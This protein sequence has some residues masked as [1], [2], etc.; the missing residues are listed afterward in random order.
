MSH[1][2]PAKPS[3]ATT[4]AQAVPGPSRPAPTPV[5]TLVPSA[6]NPTS[7]LLISAIGLPP[8]AAV[9]CRSWTGSDDAIE[10]ARK[11]VFGIAAGAPDISAALAA[12]V[13]PDLRLTLWAFAVVAE[14]G[15]PRLAALDFEDEGL[16]ETTP[17]VCRFELSH[18]HPCSAHCAAGNPCAECTKYKPPSICPFSSRSK[19][20]SRPVRQ[21][22]G[23]M[24]RLWI[25]ALRALVL[26]RL[27][28]PHLLPT[29]HGVLLNPPHASTGEWGRQW[30][31]QRSLTHAHV[32]ISLSHPLPRPSSPSHILIHLYPHQT[33][34]YSLPPSN[35]PLVPGTPLR[36]LPA[37][38]PAYA[39]A[40]Y[41]GPT[42]SGPFGFPQLLG[43]RGVP[44]SA[45]VSPCILVWL[46]L[47]PATTTNV[48]SPSGLPTPS[49]ATPAA[50]AGPTGSRGMYAIWPRN[51]C[52]VDSKL[53]TIDVA[54]LPCLPAGL[55]TQGPGWT[56]PRRFGAK[57]SKPPK[58]I[59]LQSAVSC[60]PSTSTTQDGD[61]SL[62]S[63]ANTAS[64]LI[65]AVVR[66]REKEKEKQRAR[67]ER[68][69]SGSIPALG[70]TSG[71]ATGPSTPVDAVHPINTPTAPQ[72][73]PQLNPH[74]HPHPHPQPQPPTQTQ[75]PT[76]LEN[77]PMQYVG[78][79]L[80]LNP[81][82]LQQPTVTSPTSD[83][84][85]DLFGDAE[86][87]V[88]SDQDGVFPDLSFTDMDTWNVSE[89]Q[90]DSKSNDEVQDSD[91][92]FFGVADPW[93][94]NAP[95]AQAPAPTQ[96]QAQ[97]QA[98][99][100]TQMDV[101]TIDLELDV[102]PSPAKD[103]TPIP[104]PPFFPLTPPQ[105]EGG[106]EPLKFGQKYENVDG[107]YSCQDGK[108]GVR[109]RLVVPEPRPRA[110]TLIQAQGTVEEGRNRLVRTQSFS[111]TPT[112]ALARR[113]EVGLGLRPRSAS[114][115]QQVSQLQA[116]PL[117]IQPKP[118]PYVFQAR[119]YPQL[120]LHHLPQ[121][122]IKNQLP[123]PS[124]S[125]N[126]RKLRSGYINLTNP[127]AKRIRTLKLAHSQ[128]VA[129][130]GTGVFTRDW[131]PIAAP[132]SPTATMSSTSDDEGDDE[133][134]DEYIPGTAPRS[135]A[136]SRGTT[137][138]TSAHPGG[139]S[140]PGPGL[141]IALF[142]PHILGSGMLGDVLFWPT[143]PKE[144]KPSAPISVPT[145][146]SPGEVVVVEAVEASVNVLARE[147]VDNWTWGTDQHQTEWLHPPRP[148][149][150]QLMLLGTCLGSLAPG[151]EMSIGKLTAMPKV[152]LP[153]PGILTDRPY[154]QLPRLE[155]LRQPRVSIGHSGQVVQMY[156]PALKFWEAAGLEPVGGVK[157]VVA[158]A[159]YEEGEDGG[160]ARRW[161]EKV[162]QVYEMRRLGKHAI[163]ETGGGVVPVKWE[164]MA[165]TLVSFVSSLPQTQSHIV[166]YLIIP[167]RAFA[168]PA[169]RSFI[170][171]LES[172][173]FIST[174]SEHHSHLSTHL[175]PAS[176]LFDHSTTPPE[177]RQ[178]LESTALS[179]Y[180]RI[181]RAI[182]RR[183]RREILPLDIPA[184]STV[185]VPAYTLARPLAPRF[186]FSMDW[187]DVQ[188]EVLDRHM[189][190]HVGY[191]FSK[192][193]RWL[194]ATCVDER[195]E[196]YETK[197]W[198]GEDMSPSKVVAKVWSF[199]MRFAKRAA[200]E[201]RVV[202]CKMGM[203][204]LGEVE[205]WEAHT[206][207]KL[208]GEMRIG[209]HV[210]VLHFDLTT[211]LALSTSASPSVKAPIAP[212]GIPP[213]TVIDLTANDYLVLPGYDTE[214][215][216][217]PELESPV[218]DFVPALLPLATAH[219]FRLSDP[220][221]TR[222]M[223][224]LADIPS[225]PDD[226]P[227]GVLSSQ[228]HL[229][230]VNLTQNSSLW[231][232]GGDPW[233]ELLQSFYALSALTQARFS[234]LDPLPIHLAML[235]VI[236]GVS[237][238]RELVPVD[239]PLEPSS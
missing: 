108:F 233:R 111:M 7:S 199:A 70:S 115:L 159:V 190:L 104:E 116:H 76:S 197:L 79:A 230:H 100:Q 17:A 222:P 22:L 238:N 84:F 195:G 38:A 96:A 183:I 127:S 13:S 173:N 119:P 176:L 143:D 9:E 62:V 231:K 95:E 85:M 229:L 55:S 166:L 53:P 208:D 139:T 210:S 35:A 124:P 135:A 201:W 12:V 2:L 83:T 80:A 49:A 216:T 89:V 180:D 88:P 224:R 207:A 131:V 219:Y 188:R 71:V 36:L 125:P 168:S 8:S 236:L 228:L 67:M 72:S 40:P 30:S 209:M 223:G 232:S 167:Q 144:P 147:A 156:P 41:T 189:F 152:D 142:R 175:V 192:S 58:P 212:P 19:Q 105:E 128:P 141:L 214:I 148:S 57:K 64:N 6:L 215:C 4:A 77:T 123:T 61:P 73:I 130:A 1:P 146:V 39:L 110:R 44:P 86:F 92:D 145:P 187:P 157:D 138:P 3:A 66:A 185:H 18:L 171:T 235:N 20:T 218:A 198:M 56:K 54:K 221:I 99:A 213:S 239:L 50:T 59:S 87:N 154:P 134:E 69:R 118:P 11:H 121:F 184:Q 126:H 151:S 21:P 164:S 165:K 220:P 46:P 129:S 179:I 137:P 15:A 101:D 202:F 107:K 26:E 82:I 102:D 94:G 162:A 14:A 28:D 203:M 34:L 140:P 200:I 150:N 51:L 52:V 117:Q 234:S 120:Q 10:N 81:P 170:P 182:G 161:M 196:A 98:Q 227:V 75:T 68:A 47:P 153:P 103:P 37:F 5:P 33:S 45:T 24:Y 91:F 32:H 169:L 160:V 27:T 109:G 122:Q 172:N 193:K 60:Q 174:L 113:M 163:G 133:D 90:P 217:I 205:A 74:P 158:Y 31:E 177:S 48:A 97:A 43:M 194:G 29:P 206:S 63:L 16:I 211:G 186:R 136:P 78:S 132:Q 237:E 42:P 191:G 25:S 112:V 65:E 106:W 93:D 226:P 181:P 155:K 225:K 149:R 178:R 23:D 204:E 114:N